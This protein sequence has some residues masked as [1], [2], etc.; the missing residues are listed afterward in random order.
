[1]LNSAIWYWNI[2]KCGNAV[3]HVN[4]HFLLYGFFL[5]LMT[6]SMHVCQVISVTSDSL[7]PQGLQEPSGSSVHGILQ[8]GIL[9]WI[10][11][12]S[13]K[14]SSQPRDWTHTFPVA[15]I[16]QANSLPLSHQ[17][18]PNDLLLAVYFRQGKSH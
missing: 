6:Y 16:W 5:L 9:E 8:A 3:H 7:P 11:M 18:S 14:V 2:L 13:S 10:A 12:P 17:G 15:P 1:M 4:A